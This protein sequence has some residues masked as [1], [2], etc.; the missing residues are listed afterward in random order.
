MVAN[1]HQEVCQPSQDDASRKVEG[2]NHD[3]G[4][5]FHLEI[6]VKWLL[7]KSLA[8]STVNCVWDAIYPRNTCVTSVAN[9]PYLK[10]AVPG[11]GPKK[12][13]PAFSLGRIRLF[14]DLS[15]YPPTSVIPVTS[16]VFC[17]IRGPFAAIFDRSW[18]NSS[19]LTRFY[20][21]WGGEWTVV[22]ETRCS[23]TKLL[24][25]WTMLL[26][27]DLWCTSYLYK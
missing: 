15:R 26:F 24:C 6:S 3:T 21:T 22:T 7:T 19:H 13:T 5:V 1:Y 14:M 18:S 12:T 10:K 8:C 25:L 27:L 17:S 2:S 4:K 11:V 23:G 20:S 9:V 16:S